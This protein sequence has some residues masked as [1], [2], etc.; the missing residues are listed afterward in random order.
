MEVIVSQQNDDRKQQEFRDLIEGA[1]RVRV[2]SYLGELYL[3]ADARARA[4]HA[5]SD[6]LDFAKKELEAVRKKCTDRGIYYGHREE[7]DARLALAAKE[8]GQRW[9]EA[10]R[11]ETEAELERERI[12]FRWRAARAAAELGSPFEF[13]GVGKPTEQDLARKANLAAEAQDAGLAKRV[14]IFGAR[15]AVKVHPGDKG[16]HLN[17][18]RPLLHVVGAPDDGAGCCIL[19]LSTESVRVP[20]HGAM[21][22]VGTDKGDVEALGRIGAVL[23]RTAEEAGFKPFDGMDAPPPSAAK[24][25]RKPKRPARPAK[26]ARKAVRR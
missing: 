21:G 13:H 2:A 12:A 23:V 19:G 16:L 24:R 4:A 17:H 7:I 11:R 5:D 25:Q 22:V 6:A 3:V 10:H 1:L 9:T 26:R 8:L 20:D 14:G 18:G 15:P